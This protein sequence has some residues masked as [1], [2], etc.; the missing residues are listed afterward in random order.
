MNMITMEGQPFSAPRTWERLNE[1]VRLLGNVTGDSHP[2]FKVHR[3]PLFSE[4]K[5]M[6]RTVAVL[7]A[8]FPCFNRQG[9]GFDMP[10]TGDWPNVILVGIG[11]RRIGKEAIRDFFGLSDGLARRIVDELPSPE[12]LNDLAGYLADEAPPSRT[13]QAASGPQWPAFPKATR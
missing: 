2:A 11:G 7:A 13:P 12:L 9:L 4:E 6:K 10:G 5:S 3:S 1:L 8:R